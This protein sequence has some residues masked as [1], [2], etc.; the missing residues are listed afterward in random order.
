MSKVR[1]ITPKMGSEIGVKRALTPLAHGM[2]DFFESFLPRRWMGSVDPFFGKRPWTEFET[3]M[4]PFDMRFDML[5]R[6]RDLALRVELPGVKKEDVHIA[7]S[8]EYLT[9]EAHRSF[10]DEETT[11]NFFRS[12]LGTGKLARTIVLPVEVEPDKVMATLKEGMLEI[13]LP[14]AKPETRHIVKV[15]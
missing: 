5:D 13:I 1:K 6:D 12:E 3:M 10:K 4:E 14:K 9:V 11:E 2:E 8:G 15:A 7:I